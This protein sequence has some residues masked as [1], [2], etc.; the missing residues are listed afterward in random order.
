MLNISDIFIDIDLEGQEANVS[1]NGE[2][3]IFSIDFL[4]MNDYGDVAI[5]IRD[6]EY[7]EKVIGYAYNIHSQNHENIEEQIRREI[8]SLIQEKYEDY[9]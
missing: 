1:Y 7:R 8:I 9:N 4:D 2:D 3:L 6:E 5:H